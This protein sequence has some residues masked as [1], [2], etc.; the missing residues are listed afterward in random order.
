MSPEGGPLAAETEETETEETLVCRVSLY[1][2]ARTAVTDLH[3]LADDIER[4]AADFRRVGQP[5]VTSY[6]SVAARIQRAVAW[7][8]AN[9]SLDRLT[10]DAVQADTAR[11]RALHDPH[12]ESARRYDAFM[13]ADAEPR[14]DAEQDPEDFRQAR[15][16][17]AAARR[18]TD[19]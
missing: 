12:A 19:S 6:A 1:P 4:I 8:L 10:S 16:V 3:R 13:G 9:A 2:H 7:G 15:R 11:L 17:V 18:G 14:D 5:G